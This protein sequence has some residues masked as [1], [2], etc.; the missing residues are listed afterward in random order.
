MCQ[1]SKDRTALCVLDRIAQPNAVKCVRD[2]AID[3]GTMASDTMWANCAHHLVR[4]LSVLRP[5]LAVFHGV[6]ARWHVPNAIGR[7]FLTPVDGEA[8]LLKG[9]LYEWST[10]GAHVLFLPHPS[11]GWLDRAWDGVVLPA[12]KYMRDRGIIP[13]G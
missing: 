11:R 2:D 5:N 3:R 7:E 10:L 9:I 6:K 12:I 13:P 4:E 1:K 8:D